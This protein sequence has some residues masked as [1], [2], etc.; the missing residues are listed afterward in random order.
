MAEQIIS[1]DRFRALVAEQ[2]QS[3]NPACPKELEWSADLFWHELRLA[4]FEQSCEDA[5]CNI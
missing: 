5:P 3:D 1:I 4:Q 2:A